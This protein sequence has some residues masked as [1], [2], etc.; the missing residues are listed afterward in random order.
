MKTTLFILQG[1]LALAK[2]I[3]TLLRD[4]IHRDIEIQTVDIDPKYDRHS[5]LDMDKRCRAYLSFLRA[6]FMTSDP[7][8]VVV[9][10]D[11][12]SHWCYLGN[13]PEYADYCFELKHVQMTALFPAVAIMGRIVMLP[14]DFTQCLDVYPRTFLSLA[15]PLDLGGVEL[16]D[17]TTEGT[18]RHAVHRVALRLKQEW[19]NLCHRHM[20]FRR[21]L[22]PDFD[23]LSRLLKVDA[24]ILESNISFS[25]DVTLTASVVEGKAIEGTRSRVVIELRNEGGRALR[26]IRVR[27]RAPFS[28][29]ASS[30]SCV[31]DLVPPKGTRLEL[32]LTPKVAPCCPVELFIDLGDDPLD[33]P[34]FPI[35]VLIDV[36]PCVHPR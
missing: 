13:L 22:K 19:K 20:E 31:L 11:R 3:S 6:S 9:M 23:E 7:F 33:L 24:A 14:E 27:V 2:K 16:V 30:F 17:Y 36:L 32:E 8:E 12:E 25:P 18:I 21:L 15:R 26:N 35:P 34:S 5:G 29:M 4:E 10:N 1:Q 28:V